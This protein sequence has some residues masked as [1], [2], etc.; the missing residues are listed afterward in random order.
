[1]PTDA[2]R[3]SNG[4]LDVRGGIRFRHLDACP[5]CGC[6]ELAH[7]LDGGND[8]ETALGSFDV[9]ECRQCG[10]Q[11]TVPQPLYEDVHLLY[12]DRSSHDFDDSRSFV[13]RL[14]RFNHFR[15]LKRLPHRVRGKSGVCLDYGCGAGF[16]TRSMRQYLAGRV[17][18][19]DF[20]ED[21]PPLLAAAPDIEYVPD[22]SLDMLQGCL[23]LIVCRNV[24][25]HTV[26][27]MG[28]IARLHRLL[29]T[30][31][32]VLIEVPNRRSS[33]TRLLG[34]Y[35][36]NYYL[37]RHVY[38]YDESSLARQLVSFI[39]IGRWLDHSPILG[40]SFGSMLGRNVSG[41]ALAGLLLLPLQ[42]IVDVPL[43]RSSQL[44]VIAERT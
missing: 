7:A 37:P 42:L 12:D 25:E 22:S 34:R 6:P 32:I 36:F 24:L 19:S 15:Q 30:G 18:G 20:H 31:G 3:D 10:I 4:R 39:I 29:K 40:K 26:D 1:M 17:I 2:A 21:P 35:C 44:V 11:F 14:R 27:P 5:C 9:R 8:F 13:D 33:W 43:G 38:H 16:F 23:D 28:F 41:Y